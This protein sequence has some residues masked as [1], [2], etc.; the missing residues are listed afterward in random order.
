MSNRIS[1]ARRNIIW[2][3]LNSIV[4][5][6]FP[7]FLRTV[8]IYTLGIEYAGLGNLFTSILQILSLSELGIGS[9]LVFCM[10]QP[11]AEKDV[12]TIRALLKFYKSCYFIIGTVIL[13]AGVLITPFIQHLVK[14]DYP[15]EINIYVLYL[16]YLINTCISYFFCGYKR[17]LFA[18]SQRLD[19][20]SKF[21]MIITVIQYLLQILILIKFKNYYL[22]I[23]LLPL[24]TLA[25]NV[26]LNKVLIKSFPT[27]Y[28]E[29]KIDNEFLSVIKKKVTGIMFQKIGTVVLTS[30]DSIVISMYFGLT[31]LGVYNNYYF[32]IS[33]LFSI[34]N[35]ILVSIIPSIGNSIV[36]E[37]IEKNK[38][39]FYMFNF[40]YIF[41]ISWCTTC[42]FVLYQ[43]FMD[44][45]IG[46]S[47]GENGLLSNGIVAVLSLYFY[48]LKMGDIVHVYKEGIGLW[49]QAKY[50]PIISALINLILNLVSV[51]Y[52]GLYGVI[53]SS[54]VSVMFIYVPAN[55]Y[56]LYK[57]YFGN[58]KECIIYLISQL[59]YLAVSMGMTLL[60]SIICSFNIDNV[61]I[62][63]IIKT[64]ICIMLTSISYIVVYSKNKYFNEMIKFF[65]KIILKRK[66]KRQ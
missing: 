33:A 2:S 36:L 54:I 58:M 66:L 42:L 24:C 20:E 3:V 56:V 25:T 15:S 51:N 30:V 59:K 57:N 37:N 65:K 40:I 11:M 12:K 5:L 47:L 29:G 6:V 48:V 64:L 41:I 31:V 61:F 44:V 38:N 18:A 28:P 7:F 63:F 50:I 55:T 27:Y 13:L 45:W 16:I 35:A 46:K 43:P 39:D 60:I 21:V 62:N 34:L 52:I 49:E 53:I 14:G 17:V 4:L 32:V 19:L 9:A 8:M 26:L 22:Y 23:I 10:Y 1:N